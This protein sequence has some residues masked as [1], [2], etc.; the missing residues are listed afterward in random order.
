MEELIVTRRTDTH[1]TDTLAVRQIFSALPENWLVRGLEERDYGIDLSIELF[2]GENPTG[3]F[4]LIQV[5][6][7]NKS[8]GDS[9]VSL[10]G[11]PTKTLEYAQLFPEAF[12]IFHTSIEDKKTY[13]VWAQKYIDV[14]LKKDTPNWAKQDSNTINFPKENV[15]GETAGNDKIETIMKILSAKKSGLEF[16]YD[17][18]WL[19]THWESYK[20]GEDKLLDKCIDIA[21]KLRG[22]APFYTVYDPAILGVDFFGLLNSLEYFLHNP[23]Q[24]YSYL[25]EDEAR[26]LSEVDR[27]ILMLDAMKMTF[28][29]QGNMDEFQEEHSDTSPY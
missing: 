11:F 28:L 8:F 6:G 14:R 4:S 18:E 17:F 12:F 13:F 21:K 10:S 3:C 15:V 27:H 20:L 24:N 16:L 23:I 7:K 29:S 25:Y 9:D 22:H 26:N 19:K 5:K 1:I 2:D